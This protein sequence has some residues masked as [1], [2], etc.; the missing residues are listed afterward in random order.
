MTPKSYNYK[1]IIHTYSNLYKDIINFSN[2]TNTEILV[3]C[4]WNLVENLN[5][6]YVKLLIEQKNM[7]VEIFKIYKKMNKTD[8]FYPIIISKI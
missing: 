4:K 3:F 6:K 5:W 7:T 1:K 2:I 8:D